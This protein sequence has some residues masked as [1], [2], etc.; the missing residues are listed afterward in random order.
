MTFPE[1]GD[2]GSW[3]K[4]RGPGEGLS[5]PRDSWARAPITGLRGRT[6]LQRAQGNRIRPCLPPLPT[7]TAAPTPE[8]AAF[9]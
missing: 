4:A 3:G 6:L 1:P 9:H 5:T 2:L 8:L 7:S